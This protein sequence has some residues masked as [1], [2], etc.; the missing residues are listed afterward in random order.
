M[1]LRLLFFIILC[2]QSMKALENVNLFMKDFILSR[3]P[4][5][6]AFAYLCWK[7]GIFIILIRFTIWIYLMFLVII[8]FSE[9]S[10]SLTKLFWSQNLFINVKGT[11]DGFNIT[12]YEN[13]L[14]L[15]LTCPF[16]EKML[17]EVNLPWKIL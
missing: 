12:N 1:K 10:V 2:F 9:F 7:T 17:N 4:V 15:D 6:K 13:T 8:I 16:A 14:I 3:N 11:F 5:P